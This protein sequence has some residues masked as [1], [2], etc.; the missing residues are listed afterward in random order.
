LSAVSRSISIF[1]VG[2]PITAL[3]TNA[4]ANVAHRFFGPY[5]SIHRTNLSQQK[6]PAKAGRPCRAGSLNMRGRLT[7]AAAQALCGHAP[8]AGHTLLA[9][10][11][12]EVEVGVDRR[13]I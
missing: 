6:S 13:R 8:L 7:L 9:G 2:M 5:H 12:I 11:V 1:V 4:R 3:A 10:H